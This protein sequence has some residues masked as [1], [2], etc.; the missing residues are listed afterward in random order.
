MIKL[1]KSGTYNNELNYLTPDQEKHK[2]IL[3]IFKFVH[4]FQHHYAFLL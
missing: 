4:L 1:L 3:N 2:S